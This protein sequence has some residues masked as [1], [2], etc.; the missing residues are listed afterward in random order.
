M[1]L[2]LGARDAVGNPVEMARKVLALQ[3]LFDADWQ[4]AHPVCTQN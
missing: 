3:Q 2:D 1:H 4:V